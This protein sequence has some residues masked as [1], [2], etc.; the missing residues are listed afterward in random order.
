MMKPHI[1][2][3]RYPASGRIYWNVSNM[4]KPYTAEKRKLWDAATRFA[5]QLNNKL[6][7][8]FFAEL[9]NAKSQTIS[10]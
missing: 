9:L 8:R 6:T 10:R 7:E 5:C 3:K 2:P 4:P 1:Y